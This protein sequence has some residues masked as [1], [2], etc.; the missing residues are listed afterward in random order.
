MTADDH[1]TPAKD[2]IEFPDI[3]DVV[4]AVPDPG[5]PQAQSAHD[6]FRDF[7]SLT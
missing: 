2:A 3:V 5:F 4:K 7:I 1:S 6:D